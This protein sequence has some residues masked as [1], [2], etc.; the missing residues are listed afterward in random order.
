MIVYSGRRVWDAQATTDAYVLLGTVW[1]DDNILAKTIVI[2]EEGATNAAKIKVLGGVATGDYPVTILPEVVLAAGGSRMVSIST[3][4]PYVAIYIKAASGGSQASI[5]AIGRGIATSQPSDR[6]A[7]EAVSW[8]DS[9]AHEASAV[10]KSSSGV[11]KAV[12]VHNAGASDQ[13]VQVHDSATLPADTAVPKISLKVRA[14]ANLAISLQDGERS[15]VNGIVV[16]NSSTQ[17]TKTIGSADCWF[18]VQY[19]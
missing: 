16:C 19:K 11:L 14:G 12:T 5:S 18:N 1:H 7:E 17:P 2:K 3:Y 9:S 8:Y 13:Y 10:V 15:C 6:Q 4:L